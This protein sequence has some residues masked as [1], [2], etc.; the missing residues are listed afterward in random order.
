[1]LIEIKGVYNLVSEDTHWV[2]F[3]NATVNY[4]RKEF[5]KPYNEVDLI[6]KSLK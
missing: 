5:T 3:L 4:I 2:P 6:E 1:M